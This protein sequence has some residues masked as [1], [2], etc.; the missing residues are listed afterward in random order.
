MASTEES[1]HFALRQP[2]SAQ[3]LSSPE[4]QFPESCVTLG[5]SAFRPW[6][7]LRFLV[8]CMEWPR[9]EAKPPVLPVQA[10]GQGAGPEGP[11]GGT[12]DTQ[13]DWRLSSSKTLKDQSFCPLGGWAWAS[14]SPGQGCRVLLAPARAPSWRP[15]DGPAVGAGRPE[16]EPAWPGPCS[17]RSSTDQASR[18][19]GSGPAPWGRRERR[20]HPAS[21]SPALTREAWNLQADGPKE[22]KELSHL[23]HGL[24]S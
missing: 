3:P 11:G 19:R 5:S 10:V 1:C 6:L 8:P 12:Q 24:D 2:L 13:G 17:L 9:E 22:A 4:L 16:A 15:A 21:M 23:L 7:K 18:V 14:G 20:R